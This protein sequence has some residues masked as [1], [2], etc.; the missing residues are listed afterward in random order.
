MTPSSPLIQN[1]LIAASGPLATFLGLALS[2][3]NDLKQGSVL[4]LIVAAASVIAGL[5]ALRVSRNAVTVKQG[6]R[7]SVTY[8]E[9]IYCL[10]YF[11]GLAVFDD[12]PLTAE[13]KIMLP[14]GLLGFIALA[15]PTAYTVSLSIISAVRRRE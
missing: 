9:I 11:A 7:R 1:L 4:L 14:L 13:Q 2:E 3:F 6:V 10:I 5:V 8:T 15:F 12:E